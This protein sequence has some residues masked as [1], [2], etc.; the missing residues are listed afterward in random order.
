MPARCHLA[1]VGVVAA[2][3]A[4]SC[5]PDAY[6]LEAAQAEPT[7]TA[8]VAAT[9]EPTPAPE[10]TVTP[11]PTA[12]PEPAP[13]VTPEPTATPEP[14]PTVTPEPTVDDA[15]LFPLVA[16]Q[17]SLFG[18]PL[19]A[20]T[21]TAVAYF[22]AVYQPPGS[23]TGWIEGCPLDGLGDNERVITWGGLTV[24]FY[25]DDVGD[26]FESWRFSIDPDSLEAEPGGPAVDDVVLPGGW[27][28]G[29]SFADVVSDYGAEPTVDEVFGVPLYFDDAL[30]L[31][32]AGPDV[33]GPVIEVGTPTVAFCE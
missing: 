28:L 33:D 12:T 30:V 29:D 27:V 20:G 11:E 16:G 26:Y 4:V 19:G 3:V 1:V 2:V 18:V 8:A 17:P 6:D 32:G 7:P 5:S 22:T 9:P 24:T 25:R 15:D 21:D 31:I 13:T 10:P 23:D 14:E